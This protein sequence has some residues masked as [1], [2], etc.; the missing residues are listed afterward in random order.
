MTKI[1][2]FGTEIGKKAML[3]GSGELG[4]EVAIELVRL[5]VEVVACDRYEGAP[6][7]QIAQKSR[8]FNMLDGEALRSAIEEERPDHIIPEVE[9]IAT[10]PLWSLKKRASMLLLPPTLPD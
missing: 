4:K 2:S 3:L 5:G 6:A 8:T 1:G 7:M 9:A 10:L